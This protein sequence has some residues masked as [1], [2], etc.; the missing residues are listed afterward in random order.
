MHAAP[1][2]LC[3]APCITAV[4]LRINVP[5]TI[6]RKLISVSW[7]ILES[8]EVYRFGHIVIPL[9]QDQTIS[10]A[11]LRSSRDCPSNSDL[12]VP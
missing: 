10:W 2:I 7:R 8:A 12:M 1:M 5:T 6:S 9:A 4:S 3:G 11:V